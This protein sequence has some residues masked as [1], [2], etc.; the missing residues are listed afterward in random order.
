[1]PSSIVPAR[2]TACKSFLVNLGSFTSTVFPKLYPTVDIINPLQG[3]FAPVEVAYAIAPQDR[4]SCP[5]FHMDEHNFPILLAS[6]SV[7]KQLGG[8]VNCKGY[9]VN[10]SIL[11]PR[12]W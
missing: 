1:M 4:V 7:H 10:S 12:A 5:K 6:E 9:G 2:K 11:L 8:A 3:T